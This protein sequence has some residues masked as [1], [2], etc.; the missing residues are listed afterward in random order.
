MIVI[1]KDREFD[2]PGTGTGISRWQA[3]RLYRYE[4]N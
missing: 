2:V 4:R 1:A 3:K